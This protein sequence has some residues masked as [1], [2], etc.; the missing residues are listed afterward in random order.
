MGLMIDDIQQELETIQSWRM[1]YA[2][3]EG[4]S[5]AH[6]LSKF[7]LSNFMTIQWFFEPAQRILDIIW[8]EQIALSR[9]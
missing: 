3:S 2:N 1:T 6:F 8:R 4:N 7:A 5:A 9:E